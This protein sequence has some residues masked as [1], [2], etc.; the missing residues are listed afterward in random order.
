MSNAATAAASRSSI[1]P[2]AA[3]RREPGITPAALA[4]YLNL[5]PPSL[6]GSGI[7]PTRL[8][9]TIT[10]AMCLNFYDAG[11]NEIQPTAEMTPDGWFRATVKHYLEHAEAEAKKPF[12]AATED[13]YGLDLVFGFHD[14]Y[15]AKILIIGTERAVRTRGCQRSSNE[16]RLRPYIEYLT[17]ADRKL[18]QAVLRCLAHDGAIVTPETVVD[19]IRDYHWH[20]E[21]DESIVMQ[22]HTDPQTGESLYDGITR[23]EVD[24]TY[25]DWLQEPWMRLKNGR[26]ARRQHISRATRE[27]LARQRSKD[28]REALALVEAIVRERKSIKPAANALFAAESYEKCRPEEEEFLPSIVT[29][30]DDEGLTHATV[31]MVYEYAM[32][33][34]A[35]EF[36]TLSSTDDLNDPVHVRHLIRYLIGRTKILAWQSVLLDRIAQ[37]AIQDQ[38]SKKCQLS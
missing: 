24:E 14:A 36:E 3:D 8:P 31:D 30:W 27:R 6:Q 4:S 28:V 7:G 29:T 35:V 16:R 1:K 38:R 20:G 13:A 22:E 9:D 23:K 15:E 12:G 37:H 33:G 11:W 2:A 26:Y 10:T 5:L 32:Q 17:K 21:D 25:P 18:A 19:M 34:G